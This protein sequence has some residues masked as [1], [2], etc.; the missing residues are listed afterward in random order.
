MADADILVKYNLGGAAPP[1]A[2]GDAAILA[3]YGN[4]PAAKKPTP[5]APKPGI[6][7][8]TS[9]TGPGSFLGLLGSVYN[10]VPDAVGHLGSAALDVMRRTGSAGLAAAADPAGRP[11]PS[12][13]VAGAKTYGN[14]FMQG[15]TPQQD[16][17][18]LDTVKTDLGVKGLIDQLPDSGP[19]HFLK[20]LADAAVTAP[21][22][23]LTGLGGS[24]LLERGANAIGR[25]GYVG[26]VQAL[27]QLATKAPRTAAVIGAAHDFVTPGGSRMG[28][29]KR[30]LVAEQGAPGLDQYAL[31]R[32]IEKAGKNTQSGVQGALS[33]LAK[34]A[35][36]GLSPE[37]EQAAYSAVNA[38]TAA[39]NAPAEQVKTVLDSLKQLQGTGTVRDD[40]TA[41]GYQVPPTV[42]PFD[43]RVRGLQNL[44][45]VRQDYFPQLHPF[46][47]EQELKGLTL[48]QLAGEEPILNRAAGGQTLNAA[49]PSLLPRS[50][51]LFGDLDTNRQALS[52][53]IYRGARSIGASDTMADLTKNFGQPRAVNAPYLEG[54]PAP[55]TFGDVPADIRNAFTQT[56]R[57][58]GLGELLDQAGYGNPG[59]IPAAALEGLKKAT[60]GT[61]SAMFIMPGNPHILNELEMGLLSKP[62]TTIGTTARYLASGEAIPGWM[63]R[64]AIQQL[65]GVRDALAAQ[66]AS[67][68]RALKSG[69]TETFDESRVP[70]LFRKV[71]LGPLADYS[72]R[73]LWG[74]A[75]ALRGGV[76]DSYT[77]DFLAQGV[78]QRMAEA[79][80]AQATGEDVV[81]Y[82]DK[83]DLTNA[84]SHVLPF[85]TY[86]TKKPGV[87]A[88]A[89]IR[90]PERVLAL[91]RNNPNFDPDRDQKMEGFDAGRPL[92]GIYNAANN[93]SPG[94]SP[95]PF[96]GAQYAR[97]S[98]GSPLR[99]LLGLAGAHYFTYGNPATHGDTPL[100]GWMKLLLNQTAGNVPFVGSNPI[101]GHESDTLL[102]KLGLNYFAR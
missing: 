70:D 86:A 94:S 58:P 102:D 82:A 101:P 92:S 84:L 48:P 89:A 93:Q 3:K 31:A 4:P 8:A 98:M 52:N 44:G 88:R 95:G 43:T 78:P 6:D 40:L 12:G 53:R 77:R 68:G 69:A 36:T 57:Q 33:G 46:T 15:R 83:S 97:A 73:T 74:Y 47:D 41:T 61:T 11:F 80:A 27:N 71:G 76:N 55:P 18:N 25:S 13:L 50:A 38:G 24:G 20:G 63:G 17:A 21:F 16:A 56:P 66:N 59:A 54:P 67:V 79:K 90:H 64:D 32:S 85:A 45:Q 65:P 51:D 81:N 37:E 34:D 49:D 5:A 39:G 14:A 72:N 75:N 99:D 60:R 23:I 35:T 30:N 42:A 62:A 29:L 1:A 91:T 9:V 96:P 10:G 87:I 28:A 100:E 7:A 26:G 2:T 19:F 22:D